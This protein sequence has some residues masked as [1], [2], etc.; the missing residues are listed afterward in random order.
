MLRRRPF[1]VNGPTVKTRQQNGDAKV[2]LKT[3]GARAGVKTVRIHAR[4]SDP[5]LPSAVR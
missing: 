2:P 1:L 5:W 3:G 4:V